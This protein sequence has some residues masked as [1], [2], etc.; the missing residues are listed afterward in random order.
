MMYILCID[1]GCSL[2]G[3][4]F[5]LQLL[6]PSP[7]APCF[8]FSSGP[9]RYRTPFPSGRPRTLGFLLPHMKTPSASPNT[10]LRPLLMP[11]DTPSSPGL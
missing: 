10:P 4:V 3:Q 5:T 1:Q 11:K 2:A 8:T 6:L 7:L 9:L